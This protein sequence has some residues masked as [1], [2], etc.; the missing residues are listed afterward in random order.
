MFASTSL[1]NN[2]TVLLYPLFVT[3]PDFVVNC[4]SITSI[5][6]W[7]FILYSKLFINNIH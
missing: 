5:E 1:D 6:F 2:T 3:F 4:H 7:E